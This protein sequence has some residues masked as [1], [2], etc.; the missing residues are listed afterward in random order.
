MR[1]VKPSIEFLWATPNPLAVIEQAGRT[2]YKSEDKI[3]ATS[4]K[5]FAE[6]LLK[7]KHEAVIEHASASYRV[8]CDRGVTHEIVRHRLF[9][10][11]QESTRYC[12]YKGGVTFIIP[13]WMY[14]DECPPAG[15][16][17]KEHGYD[18]PDA[19][20]TWM[21]AMQ[22]AEQQ[23]L[24]LLDSGWSPQQARSVLPNS[25]KTEIVI[26]GN[27]REW[28]HFFMLRTASAAHPQMREVANMLLND[29]AG[30]IPVIF[31]EFTQGSENE[32]SNRTS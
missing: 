5:V 9:S 26:T 8:V 28:R 10:Y 32:N 14:G 15:N 17:N 27:L 23:Y 2:C 30:R 31:D 24:T 11:A 20:V 4:S 19:F 6:K 21:V 1:L 18:G 16:W 29:I 12:N 13:E 7:L 25:L 3:N 22:L